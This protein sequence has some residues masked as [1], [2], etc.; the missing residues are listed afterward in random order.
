ML[1]LDLERLAGRVA[2]ELNDVTGPQ[3]VGR[4]GRDL[5]P[6]DPRAASTAAVRDAVLVACGCMMAAQLSTQSLLDPIA[7][8]Q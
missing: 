7:S 5:L 6:V 4:V 1:Q 2:P 3:A 8:T